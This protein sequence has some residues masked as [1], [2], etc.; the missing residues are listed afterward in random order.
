MA[1]RGA[2][3]RKGAK[4]LSTS[5]ARQDKSRNMWMSVKQ[6]TRAGSIVSEERRTP[7][8]QVTFCSEEWDWTRRWRISGSKKRRQRLKLTRKKRKKEKK[9]SNVKGECRP[10]SHPPGAVRCRTPERHWIAHRTVPQREWRH[11]GPLQSHFL[12]GNKKD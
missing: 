11:L 2:V 8:Q 1:Q 7:T 5:K 10:F 6:A 3:L 9:R 4:E 12:I